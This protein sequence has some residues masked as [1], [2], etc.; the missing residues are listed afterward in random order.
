M[1][2]YFASINHSTGVVIVECAV[3]QWTGS[4]RWK[5]YHTLSAQ[6]HLSDP[7][8]EG[9]WPSSDKCSGSS[10]IILRNT[11]TFDVQWERLRGTG[12]HS[13]GHTIILLPMGRTWLRNPTREEEKKEIRIQRNMTAWEAAHKSQKH[14][15]SWVIAWG[16]IV[17]DRVYILQPMYICTNYYLGQ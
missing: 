6:R 9:R 10:K 2:T 15:I 3:P 7:W 8:T 14:F 1:T 17:F 16:R 4:R 11:I 13:E 5:A 12:E